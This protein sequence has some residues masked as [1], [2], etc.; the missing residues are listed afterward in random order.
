LLTIKY[1]CSKVVYKSVGKKSAVSIFRVVEKF[2]YETLRQ[3]RGYII[4]LSGNS[5]LCGTET[6]VVTPKGSMSTEG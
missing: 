2:T 1:K 6:G 5:D 3:Y 4:S